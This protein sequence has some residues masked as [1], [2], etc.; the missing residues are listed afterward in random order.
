MITKFNISST[1]RLTSGYTMPLLGFGVFRCN[2]TKASV[3]E[4]LKAGYRHVDSAQV[5]RNEA[6]VA[7]AIRASGVPR[8]DVFVTTKCVSKTH[9]YESTLKGVSESLKRMAFDYV[10]LFL[11]HD[12]LSGTDRRLATYKALLEAKAAGKIRSVGVS[13]YN[14]HHIEEIKKAGYEMPC[15]NQIELHPFLQQTEIVK[16]CNEN[17]IVVQAYSPLIKGNIDNPTIAALATKYNRDPAHILLRW[18]L[19]KGFVPLPKSSTPS[20]IH[21]NA[22]LYDFELTED[23][24]KKLDALDRGKAGAISWNPVDSP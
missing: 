1:V 16:Y 3:M 19:Q 4:A 11:I 20:R 8:E 2:D 24:I 22:N 14:V 5:Y 17:N 15:V 23:D 13:N 21:S 12:P 18:S 10:D 9:G 7:E 6:E